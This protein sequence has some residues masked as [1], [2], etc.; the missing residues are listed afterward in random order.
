M[1]FESPVVIVAHLDHPGVTLE[2]QLPPECRNSTG[3]MPTHNLNPFIHVVESWKVCF[4]TPNLAVVHGSDRLLAYTLPTFTTLSRGKHSLGGPIWSL[5]DV[6]GGKTEIC[7]RETNAGAANERSLAPDHRLNIH[8]S[9]KLDG[10]GSRRYIGLTT[11]NIDPSNLCPSSGILKYQRVVSRFPAN[12]LVAVGTLHPDLYHS[13]TK[14]DEEGLDVWVTP[15]E[16]LALKQAAGEGRG[17][18]SYHVY[19]SGDELEPDLEW[20]GVDFDEASGRIFIWGPAYR[21]KT[22]PETRVFVGE[23]VS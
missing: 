3:D 20:E 18:G 5:P 22:P 8:F 13:R 19:V 14:Y 23:L 21:W 16:D 10:P 15:L 17:P 1:G 2:I 4:P 12:G 9:H 11:L 6:I 7:R